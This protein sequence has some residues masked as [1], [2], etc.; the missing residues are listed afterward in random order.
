MDDVTEGNYQ[1]QLID[2]MI[3]TQQQ[4]IQ[5]YGTLYALGVD[6]IKSKDSFTIWKGDA[7]GKIKPL[8]DELERKAMS[9]NS[10]A[11]ALGD[12]AMRIS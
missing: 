11:A 5:T 6:V 9:G 2:A 8:I 12:L 1:R 7:E 3:Q 10:N 4:E